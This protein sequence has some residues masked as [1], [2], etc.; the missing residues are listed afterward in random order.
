MTGVQT[1]ALPISGA[2]WLSAHRLSPYDYFQFWRNT[3]DADVGRF[4]RLFTELPLTEIARLEAL[5]G[6]EINEAKKILAFEATKLLHGEEAA[7]SARETAHQVFEEGMLGTDVPSFMI[8]TD[9]PIGFP[10]LL[11]QSAVSVSAG[12]GRRLIEQGA[13]LVN[14]KLVTDWRA[15]F[16]ANDLGPDGTLKITRGKKRVVRVKRKS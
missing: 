10:Q 3:E 4:A 9:A 6:A 13:I 8:L 12:D 11:V 14:D 5:A 7:K 15:T 16:S 1:C 2:V